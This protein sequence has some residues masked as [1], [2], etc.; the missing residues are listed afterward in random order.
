MAKAYATYEHLQVRLILQSMFGIK[1]LGWSVDKLKDRVQLITSLQ[2]TKY[3][4][5]KKP[6]ADWLN[7]EETT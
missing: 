6:L 2:L 5:Y 1:T 7:H 3:P 4:Q